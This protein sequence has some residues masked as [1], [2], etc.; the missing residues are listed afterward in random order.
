MR[1]VVVAWCA[2]CTVRTRLLELDVSRNAQCSHNTYSQHSHCNCPILSVAALCAFPF[3]PM[4]SA[5]LYRIHAHSHRHWLH[6]PRVRLSRPAPPIIYLFIYFYLFAFLVSGGEMRLNRSQA[7]TPEAKEKETP[8]PTPQPTHHPPAFA[9]LNNQVLC[10]G[11]R[12]SRAAHIASAH[13]HHRHHH[14]HCYHLQD[15]PPPSSDGTWVAARDPKNR[16]EDRRAKRFQRTLPCRALP[17][18]KNLPTPSAASIAARPTSRPASCK[19]GHH[20][21]L[22][23]HPHKMRAAARNRKSLEGK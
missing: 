2:S 22:R 23:T 13:Y 8:P 11:S 19:P 7:H 6:M 17:H 9:A 10:C 14:H 5:I 4:H 20:E 18:G 21:A 3:R 15:G 16:S 1:C 12:C